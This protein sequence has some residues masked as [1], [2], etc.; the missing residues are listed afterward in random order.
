[1]LPQCYTYV[2]KNQL[3]QVQLLT[4]QGVKH[5][6]TFWEW[7]F[8]AKVAQGPGTS[9]Y[10]I[11]NNTDIIV[12]DE[13]SLFQLKPLLKMDEIL[14][15]IAVAKTLRNKPF[16]GIHIILMGNP[17]QHCLKLIRISLKHTCGKDSQSLYLAALSDRT[18]SSFQHCSLK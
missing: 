14:R 18:T 5:S 13:S 9:G 3:L 15:E 2:P 10:E 12:I 6:T 4:K 17:A 11:I 8:T 16:G 1:M 7:T